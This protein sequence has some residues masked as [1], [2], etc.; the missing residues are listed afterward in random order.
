MSIFRTIMLL[1]AGGLGLV[2]AV[3]FTLYVIRGDDVWM[4][5][6]KQYGRWA[7]AAVLFWFNVEIWGRVIW[8]LINWV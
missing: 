8:I 4:P 1:L 3:F 6:A 7:W 5:R 2:A